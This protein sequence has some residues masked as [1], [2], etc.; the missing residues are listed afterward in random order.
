MGFGFAIG[1]WSIW[2]GPALLT[3]LGLWLAVR[4]KRKLN[5]FLALVASYGVTYLV[6]FSL[7]MGLE[8]WHHR[9]SNS[10]RNSFG[11]IV[12]DV[13]LIFVVVISISTTLW[14][15][16]KLEKRDVT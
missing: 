11:D 5:P 14:V 16:R 9:L 6:L 12:F 10:A 3:L 4:R 7:S 15:L 13:G 1:I 2:L 8:N